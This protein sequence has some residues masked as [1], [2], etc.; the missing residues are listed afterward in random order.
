MTGD[1]GRFI[2]KGYREESDSGKLR[3]YAVTRFRRERLAG[4]PVSSLRRGVGPVAG[5]NGFPVALHIHDQPTLPGCLIQ[6]RVQFA[7]V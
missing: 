3:G 1:D 7:D 5:E 2:A 4:E 6:C